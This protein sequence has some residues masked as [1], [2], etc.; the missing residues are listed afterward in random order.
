MPS[1]LASQ[2]A[3]LIFSDCVHL[4][5]RLSTVLSRRGSHSRSI[6][7]AHIKALR[8]KW[9]AQ[10]QNPGLGSQQASMT[11]QQAAEAAAVAAGAPAA[12]NRRQEAPPPPPKALSASLLPKKR[13]LEAAGAAG[14]PQQDR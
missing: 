11:S 5:G 2:L 9:M 14:L 10:A 12:E 8:N 6:N 13:L 3:S 7:M 4:A 1:A